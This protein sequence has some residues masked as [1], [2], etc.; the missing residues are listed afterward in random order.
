MADPKPRPIGPRDAVGGRE[1]ESRPIEEWEKGQDTGQGTTTYAR[2]FKDPPR[3][4]PGVSRGR[5]MTDAEIDAYK[6]AN[7]KLYRAGGKVLSSRK[8]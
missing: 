6:R 1:V 3:G 8:F 4:P 5:G 7:P 2:Q